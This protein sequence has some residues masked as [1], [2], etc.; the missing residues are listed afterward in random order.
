VSRARFIDLDRAEPA[1]TVVVI[2]VLRAFT[3]VAWML[4]RGAERILTVAS[5]DQA[6]RIRDEQL[7][8]ALLAGEQGGVPVPDFDLGNSPSDLVDRDLTGATIVLRTSAGTLGLDRCAGSSLLL[9]ASFPVAAATAAELRRAAPGE[10]TYVVTGASLGRD[11]DEDHA[12]AELIQ[13]RLEG[14]DVD[15]APFLARVPTSDAGR[16]FG[17]AGPAWA[18]PA[19]LELACE[20]DRFPIALH[21]TAATDVEAI[22]ITPRRRRW[23]P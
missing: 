4:D 14:H 13:A 18:P 11:G 7:P 21:A 10:V 22:E 6:R 3:T 19:D 8:H 5:R 20:V 17:P 12:C 1:E 2:D 15:P 23:T 16:A 9:A